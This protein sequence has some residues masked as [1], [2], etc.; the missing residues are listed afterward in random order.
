MTIGI[1]VRTAAVLDHV[2]DINSS[3]TVRYALLIAVIM[4]TDIV[5]VL[6]PKGPLRM[7]VETSQERNEP[8]PA[9]VYAGGVT[10][11]NAAGMYF[12]V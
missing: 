6:S 7:L 2:G 3:G 11:F 4:T 8:I 12:C 9:L 1:P 5:A 10:L